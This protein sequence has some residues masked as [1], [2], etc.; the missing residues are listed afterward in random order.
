M[1]SPVVESEGVRQRTLLVHEGVVERL[2]KWAAEI[3]RRRGESRACTSSTWWK[4]SFTWQAERLTKVIS[5]SR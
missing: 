4:A 3:A 2:C 1:T 5:T